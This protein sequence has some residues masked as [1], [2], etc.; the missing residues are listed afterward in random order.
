[1]LPVSSHKGDNQLVIKTNNRQ[2]TDR[3][4]WVLNY[5]IEPER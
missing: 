4:I 5:A 3:L 2:N 1:M